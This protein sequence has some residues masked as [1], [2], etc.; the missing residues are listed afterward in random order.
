MTWGAARTTIDVPCTVDLEQ[1]QDA[2]RAYVNLEGID[3]GPGDEVII[4]DAPTTI[5]FG[6]QA[7]Y[8]RRATVRRAGAFQRAWAHSEGYLVVTEL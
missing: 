1:T 5:A 8:E 2:L 7:I 6:Q 4:H 3:V